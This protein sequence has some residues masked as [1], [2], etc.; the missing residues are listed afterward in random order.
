MSRIRFVGGTIT[1]TTGG[2]HNIYSEGNIV[3][4]SGKTVT[5]TSDVGITYGEPKDIPE[6]K[7]QDFDITF[8]LD[9]S[10][11]TIVPFGVLDFKENPENPFFCFK[12]KLSK[13]KIDSLS[14]QIMDENDAV[15]Y[16][17]TSLKAVIVKASKKTEVLFEAKKPTQGPLLSKVWDFQKIYNQYALSEPSDYTNEGEYLIHWDG[18]DDNDIYD[19]TRFNGKNLKAKIIATKGGRQK[20]LIVDFSTK[21]SEVD[22]TDVKIDKKTKR[23]DVTLR[24]NLKDGGSEGLSCWPNTRNFNPPHTKSE[25]CDWDKIPVSEIMSGKPIIKSRTKSFSDLE[26]LAIEGLNYHWGRNKNHA[27]GKSISVNGELFE[28]YVNSINVENNAIKS[29]SIKYLTNESPGRSRNW[30]LSRILYYNVGYLK[31]SK[32]WY[33]V[34]D[35]ESDSDF[36]HT[37]GHEIGHEILLAY[38]GHTYSKSHKGSSTIVT[39]SPLGDYLYPQRGE[40][41]LMIY[42]VDDKMHPYPMDYNIRGIAAEKDVLSILWLTKIKI[43]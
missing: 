32:R 9:K 26:K 12:Y 29:P 5:E 6:R 11:N 23:I 19:S 16:Q 42:Y 13:S 30:E 37:S 14:F 31:Y 4:N 41:D 34:N 15:I 10:E 2:N 28:V 39:Q 22:W 35:T 17:M 40:I 21:Y 1:K 24:V 36:K 7:N 8:E 20:S 18:F 3:Y 27:V 43:S 38:G 25:I 33:F